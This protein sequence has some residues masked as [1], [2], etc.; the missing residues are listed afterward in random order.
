[1]LVM[2]TFYYN[3]DSSLSEILNMPLVNVPQCSVLCPLLFTLYTTSL[4]PVVQSRNLVDLLF[5]E[6]THNLHCL[7]YHRH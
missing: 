7:D 1:M 4:N 5:V 2:L 6:D 3:I